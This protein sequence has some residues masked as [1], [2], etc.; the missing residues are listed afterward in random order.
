[1]LRQ[2]GVYAAFHMAAQLLLAGG[3][4]G[5]CNFF[6]FAKEKTESLCH[7]IVVPGAGLCPTAREL[8]GQLLPVL[9]AHL[10]LLGSKVALVTHYHNGNRISALSCRKSLAFLERQGKGQGQGQ[11]Q[12]NKMVQYLLAHD[13]HHLERREGIDRVH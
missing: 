1:M 5:F 3:S 11:G 7:I 8:R 12:A 9:E 10:P 13:L 6:N 2:L 4:P